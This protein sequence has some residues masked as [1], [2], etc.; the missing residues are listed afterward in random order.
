M[1]KDDKSFGEPSRPDLTNPTLYGLSYLLRNLPEGFEWD[2]SSCKNCAMGLAA[3]TWKPEK[4]NEISGIDMQEMFGVSGDVCR[5]VFYSQ[6]AYLGP[7]PSAAQIADL[8]DSIGTKNFEETRAMR[9][10]MSWF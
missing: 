8:I 9:L 3:F 6:A 2:Y 4:R 10:Q 1:F 5:Y 7:K